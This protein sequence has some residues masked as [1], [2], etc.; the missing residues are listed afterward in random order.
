MDVTLSHESHKRVNWEV[1]ST[2]ET[3]TIQVISEGVY[4]YRAI[5][6]WLEK[7]KKKVEEE[8]EGW[9]GR[10]FIPLMP[11]TSIRSIS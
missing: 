4:A 7:E 10:E 6:L 3:H 5:L 9:I 1:G 8:K 11:F 2:W